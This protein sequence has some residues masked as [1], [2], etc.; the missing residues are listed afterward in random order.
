MDNICCDGVGEMTNEE[1]NRLIAKKVMGWWEFRYKPSSLQAPTYI[2]LWQDSTNHTIMPVKDWNPTS[3]I[4]HAWIVL[5]KFPAWV[6]EK[7]PDETY[8]CAIW[9]NRQ[10]Q[11][12][13]IDAIADTAPL[14]I[15][16]AALEAVKESSPSP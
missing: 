3:R 2:P 11:G 9:K 6:V 5:E 13:S 16:L 12:G 4:D 15:C 14:S 8:Q 1:I 7:L 10:H